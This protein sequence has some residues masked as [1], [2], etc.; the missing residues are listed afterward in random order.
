MNKDTSLEKLFLHME[1]FDNAELNDYERKEQ[2]REAVQ[3]FNENNG[4]E[5]SLDLSV[6]MY[7]TWQYD[8]IDR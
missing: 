7:G 8:K 4:T 1:D 5:Y 2:L 6:K 3:A